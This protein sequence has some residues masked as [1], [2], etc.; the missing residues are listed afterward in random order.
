M[1]QRVEELDPDLSDDL[2]PVTGP[3]VCVQMT[4]TESSEGLPF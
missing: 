2:K 4:N 3:I 1:M